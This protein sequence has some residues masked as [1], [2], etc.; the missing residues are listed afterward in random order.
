MRPSTTAEAFEALL[1]EGMAPHE[2]RLEQ[3]TI[4][5]LAQGWAA[6]QPLAEAAPVP[7]SACRHLGALLPALKARV[8]RLQVQHQDFVRR[9]AEAGSDAARRAA[10]L[11]HA[12]E[13]GATRRQLWGDRRALDRWF[14]AD[15]MADR[16]ALQTGHIERRI[17]FVLRALGRLA[18]RQLR[19]S[20]DPAGDWRRLEIEAPMQSLLDWPGDPRIRTECFRGF[21]VAL[22]TLPP[23]LAMRAVQPQSL[24]FAYRAALDA[25]LDV[26]VQREALSLLCVIAP[27]DF[28]RVLATRLAEPAGGDDLFV[29]RRAIEL[30]GDTVRVA[31]GLARVAA[32]AVGD[33]S[34]HVR[35]GLALVLPTMPDDTVRS[36]WPRLGL[37]DPVAAVRA[38]AL[39][40]LPE[41]ARRESLSGEALDWLE[42]CL[43]D[44]ATPFVTRTALEVAAIALSTLDGAGRSAWQARLLPAIEALHTD[45]ASVPVRRWAAEARERIWLAVDDEARALA[46]R[47][48]PQLRRATAGGQA[49]A[50]DVANDV[51]N[52]PAD[53]PAANALTGRVLAVLAQ[54]DFGIGLERRGKRLLAWRGH[55]FGFRTWRLLYEWLAPS[56]EKRQAHRHTTGRIFRGTIRA[57]SPILAELAQTKVPGEPLQIGTEGGWRPYLP[58]VDEVISL[59][60]EEPAKGPLRLY[61]AEGVTEVVPPPSLRARLAARATLTRRFV[62]YATARNWTE[63]SPAHPN[64]YLRMLSDL[65]FT[66]RFAAHPG[67]RT[68]PAVTRFFGLSPIASLPLPELQARMENYFFSAYDNSLHDLA[69]FTAAGVAAFGAHHWWLNRQLRRARETLPLVVGGWGTRG[70]SGTERLKAAMFNALGYSVVS[71]TT[72]CEAMIL[73]GK[74]NGALRELFLFRP[75]DKATIWE[76]ADVVRHASRLGCDVFLWECMA[77]TPPF[78]R[79][80]QRS[81]MRDDFSTLTNTFP[82]HEDL[83]GPAGVDVPRVMTEFIPKGR[84]LITSEEQMRPILQQAADEVGTTLRGVGWLESG[85]IAPDV[86]A[87]FP[88][89][90]HPDNIALVAALGE[91]LGVG[92]DFAL[93]AMADRVIPDLGVLRTTAPASL[94]RRTLEFSNGMSA[95]E[96]FGCLGNWSRLGFDAHDPVEDPAT[97][98][99]TVVNNR[100][101]R[102]A[103][104]RVFAGVLVEDISADLHVLIGTNLDG[105]RGYL[106]EAWERH[107]AT[108]T[109]WPEQPVEG[110]PAA[111]LEAFARRFR[112]LRTEEQVSRRLRAML[113]AIGAPGLAAP[114]AMDS[115]AAEVRA[116]HERDASMQRGFAD[117]SMRV[118]AA[119]PAPDPGLDA[120]V[121]ERFGGWFRSRIVTVDDPN[122]SGDAV[123][124]AIRDSTPPG[125]RNRVMGIQN[126]KGTGLDFVYRWLAWDA[127]ANACKALASEDPATQRNGLAALASFREFGLL[128]H[129]TVIGTLAIA[130]R[131]ALG[132][133]PAARATLDGIEALETTAMQQVDEQIRAASASG[134]LDSLLG[135]LE[136]VIDA[137]DAV[138]RR[139]RANLVYRDLAA[140]RIGEAR[141]VVAL[142]A[143]TQR[144]KGGWLKQSMLGAWRRTR[145]IRST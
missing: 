31:P 1:V 18:S 29:R 42:R 123:I 103:R 28:E 32:D 51:A 33:P 69:I 43:R 80:M 72:G 111:V 47:I 56:P 138:R 16:V 40:Q 48:G 125:F 68:D 107:A 82:D 3:A 132:A 20:T 23:P 21:A 14:G 98:I 50:I 119:G 41:I 52:Q 134:W 5:W 70:K 54:R 116:F 100:A 96:R 136:G 130:R 140:R 77:L 128:T 2:R 60:D 79:V 8:E 73:Y 37:G 83:Q 89:Q 135:L 95:N 13:L 34:A 30:A 9:Y 76:Q 101:D 6:S 88:Y 108:L 110:G 66:F 122:A 81:W 10:I 59:L 114:D 104:S 93:K 86:L 133:E 124:A 19:D 105:L 57:P 85:L 115:A 45:A 127:C 126:I 131:S 46:Q 7:A 36:A 71:K 53:A 142:H 39:L 120:D 78:V 91:E 49:L 139:R 61:T 129:D 64:R 94:S 25:S 84:V 74:P 102:V 4:A 144:Q 113:E 58:L 118:A 35:Q 141:A 22:Q 65:G 15:A 55:R 75:Y 109:L 117:L 67:S 63:Q 106:D 112:I 99:S 137:T 92:R 26:W 24:A 62:D 44:E 11:A 145:G 90:E 38:A 17:A 27:G 121:R 143:L 87:R 12:R 97:M